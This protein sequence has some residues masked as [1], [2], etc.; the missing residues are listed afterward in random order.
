[1]ETFLILAAIL[2]AVF[3]AYGALE[4]AGILEDPPCD[5]EACRHERRRDWSRGY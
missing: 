2:A 3:L 5:C 1:M 4:R